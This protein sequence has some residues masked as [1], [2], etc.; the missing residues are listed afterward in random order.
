M[1]KTAIHVGV[2][3]VAFVLLCVYFLCIMQYYA[4]YSTECTIGL[5][6]L[7]V[8]FLITVFRVQKIIKDS[9]NQA[10]GNKDAEVDDERHP[11]HKAVERGDADMVRHLLADGYDADDTD[12]KGRTALMK[13]EHEQV[14][15][16]LINAGADVNV[17]DESGSTALMW[18]AK[19]GHTEIIQLLKDAGANEKR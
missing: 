1:S 16:L 11:L 19:Q 10:S 8:A 5:V 13:A 9:D 7:F 17:K 3:C 4:K 15:E 6:L 2:A 12:E 14:I 18:A